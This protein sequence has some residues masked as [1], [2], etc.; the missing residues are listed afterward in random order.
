M[1]KVTMRD[2]EKIN[3][4]NNQIMILQIKWDTL[5]AQFVGDGK[6]FKTMRDFDATYYKLDQA[7][8]E[9]MA[10]DNFEVQYPC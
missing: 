8:S 6:Q 5:V 2:F 10:A 7:K 3:R 4:T 9:A 1:K